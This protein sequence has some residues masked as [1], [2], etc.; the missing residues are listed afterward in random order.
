MNRPN[1]TSPKATRPSRYGPKG[2]AARAERAPPRPR[3]SPGAGGGRGWGPRGAGAD[4]LRPEGS[5]G[6]RRGGAAEAAD[7]V[8]VG[9]ERGLG[10][11]DAYDEED[12]APGGVAEAAGGP[13]PPPLAGGCL[14]GSGA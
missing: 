7:L 14:P 11:K 4:A 13:R 12:D 2:W 5:G 10:E 3:A 1:A 8:R 6:A 9:L